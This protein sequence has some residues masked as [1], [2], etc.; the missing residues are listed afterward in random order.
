[1]SIMPG[2]KQ[3][4]DHQ[5]PKPSTASG[6]KKSDAGETSSTKGIQ[7]MELIKYHVD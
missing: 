2:A 1:M 7:F 6:G 4:E 3:P 5:P